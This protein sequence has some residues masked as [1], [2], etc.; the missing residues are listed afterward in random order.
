MVRTTSE[1]PCMD[2]GQTTNHYD[3]LMGRLCPQCTIRRVD[4]MIYMRCRMDRVPYVPE[5]NTEESLLSEPLIDHSNDIDAHLQKGK[6][7]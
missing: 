5:P 7:H 4:D 6:N 1:E 2:C 3:A